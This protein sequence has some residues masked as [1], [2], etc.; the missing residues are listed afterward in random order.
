[1]LHS[2]SNLAAQQRYH[3]TLWNW[4]LYGQGWMEEEFGNAVGAEPLSAG[5]GMALQL[6]RKMLINEELDS[7]CEPTG[8]L[9]LLRMAPS[10]WLDNGKRISIENMPTAFGAVTLTVQS[11]LSRN[12]ISGKFVATNGSSLK[13]VSLWLRHPAGMPIKAVFSNGQ[14][15]SEFAVDSIPLPASGTTEFEVEF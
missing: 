8:K 14:A 5:P 15:Q 13:K 3:D 1:M 7:D 11:Q 2:T 9:E 6:I 12:K 4:D 10:K